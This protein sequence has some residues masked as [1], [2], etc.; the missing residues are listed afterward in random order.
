MNLAVV[1]AATF[2]LARFARRPRTCRSRCRRRLRPPPRLRAVRARRGGRARRRR[3]S[4]CGSRDRAWPTPVTAY[5][6]RHFG[7]AAGVM[8]TASHNPAPDNGYKVYD[9][10]GSQIIPPTDAEIAA[11]IAT[12]GPAN[13]IPSDPSSAR[14]TPHRRRRA[15]R[16]P[17]RRRGGRRT[18][19]R[20]RCASST[21]R[22]T[23]SASTCSS[24]CGSGPVSRRRSS[25]TQQ[26]KPDPDFPTAPF[27]NPEEPGVLD[28]ALDLAT[29]SPRRPRSSRTIPTPTG[30]RS[31]YRTAAGGRSSPATRSAGCSA[32]TRWSRPT[33][34]IGSSPA[35]S[36][37]RRCSTRSPTR[38]ACPPA[39]RSPASSG[40]RAPATPTAGGSCSGT[41]KRS[42]T[43]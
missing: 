18:R 20:A 1:R 21:R 23:A 5:A 17:R 32:R 27:P 34:T 24:R 30:S 2:G 37:P 13:A 19:H 29:P 25:S 38:P 33:A 35:R 4:R 22:C 11:H 39:R 15:R 9:D 14:I 3:A 8:V 26:A 43:R 7:A 16:V 31:R 42:A 28:L 6:V 36:C 40:S 10:T 12:A 41:R